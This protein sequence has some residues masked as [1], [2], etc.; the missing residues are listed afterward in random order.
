M[1]FLLFTAFKCPIGI[2]ANIIYGVWLDAC[3]S[4]VKSTNFWLSLS[5]G[6][7]LKCRLGVNDRLRIE[8]CSILTHPTV[9]PQFTAHVLPYRKCFG[10]VHRNV[11]TT[12]IQMWRKNKPY[13]L[14]STSN[15]RAKLLNSASGSS[16]VEPWLV[17]FSTRSIY[18]IKLLLWKVD[19]DT[20][21]PLVV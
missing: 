4:S 9:A 6:V 19:F 8:W 14:S 10:Y 2:S 3:C 12:S 15:W 17:A 16:W 1:L 20:S 11:E 7:F 21:G 18:A 13:S 5:C